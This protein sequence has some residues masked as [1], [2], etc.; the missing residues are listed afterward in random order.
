[1]SR[2]A[3]IAFGLVVAALVTWAAVHW[4]TSARAPRDASPLAR[5]EAALDARMQGLGELPEY[6]KRV[7]SLPSEER[8][9]V[10]LDLAVKGMPR[11]GDDALVQRAYLVSRLLAGVDVPTCGGIVTGKARP[12]RLAAAITSL[13]APALEQWLDL[14]IAAARAELV[15]SPEPFVEPAAIRDAIGA[16]LRRRAPEEAKR[17]QAGLSKLRQLEPAEACHVGRAIYD[18]VPVLGAPHDR[19]LARLLAK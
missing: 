1:M 8:R 14:T 15:E 13:D 3:R 9:A 4:V 19:V 18:E 16:L 2:G 11:L 10:V 6:A 7:A 12:A 5:Y 17:V